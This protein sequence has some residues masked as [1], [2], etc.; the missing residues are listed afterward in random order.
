M[1]PFIDS[2]IPLDSKIVL[3]ATTS[4]N[5]YNDVATSVLLSASQSHVVWGNGL[6]YKLWIGETLCPRIAMPTFSI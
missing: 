4:V 2:P 5:T 3:V 1:A 6:K